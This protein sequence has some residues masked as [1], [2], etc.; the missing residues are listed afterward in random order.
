MTLP[1]ITSPGRLYPA[2]DMDWAGDPV[3]RGYESWETDLASALEA[4]IQGA[5]YNI[6]VGF[7]SGYRSCPGPWL[8]LF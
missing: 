3:G 7:L 6:G 8:A 1:G 2:G 4:I 5:L